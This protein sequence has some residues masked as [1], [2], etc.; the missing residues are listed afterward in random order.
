MHRISI[1]QIYAPK[2]YIIHIL[3]FD[4]S[5]YILNSYEIIFTDLLN[6]SVLEHTLLW[7]NS[8]VTLCADAL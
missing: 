6:Y 3:M 2:Y 5:I 1:L 4:K 8:I 7:L